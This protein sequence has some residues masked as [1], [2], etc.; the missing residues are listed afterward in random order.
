ML[1][2]LILEEKNTEI[3]HKFETIMKVQDVMHNL[4]TVFVVPIIC[5]SYIKTTQFYE[6]KQVIAFSQVLQVIN[7]YLYFIVSQ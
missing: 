4:Q 3:L 5:L 6:T 2:S 1:I 7:T